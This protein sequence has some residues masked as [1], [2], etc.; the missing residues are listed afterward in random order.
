MDSISPL[1]DDLLARFA[2]ITGPANALTSPDLLAR[3]L[4]EPRDLYAG[5]TRL[6][7]RPASVEEVSAILTLANE[8]R[9][10]VVPQGGNTGL[11]GG[12]SPRSE[13]EIVLSLERMNRIREIDPVGRVLV[14]EA[15][16]VLAQAQSAAEEA[17]LLFP[18]SLG[19][20]GSC[21]IGG[22]LSSNAGGTGVLAYGNAR[23]LC[24]GLEAVLPSGEILNGLRKLK[25][26][27]RGYDWKDLLIGAEGTLGIITAAV[28]RLFPRPAGREVAYVGVKTPQDALTLLGIA[29]RRVGGQL[30]GFE[31]I[32]RQGMAFT[33]A[34]TKGARDPLE[35]AHPWYVLVEISS[36]RSGEDARQA[37]EEVLEAAFEASAVEDAAIAP[38]LVEA[39]RFW[40][41]REELSWAQKPE[42]GS[43]KHDVSV[44]V[45]RV[46]DFLAEADAAV[47]AAMPG[48]RIVAFGH[49]GD[50]NIHYNIS[51]PLGADK[52]AFL[53]RWHEIADIVHGIVAGYDGSF[54]AE[55]GIGQLKRDDLAGAKAGP[56]IELMRRLKGVF[57]PYRILNPGKV[58]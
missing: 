25:K 38:S 43:I 22:N 41:M 33:L 55:H 14:V 45:A 26:D 35:A 29:E 28:L 12:Q 20:Q 37:M 16:V 9:T 54:S 30:T 10:P 3:Y 53:A 34:H 32:G 44:P 47:L 23:D 40:T 42:G 56:E 46:P 18:L 36:S 24:L 39:E 58:V 27:N 6:V 19:S 51:Q 11:V 8:T 49:L 5:R 13:G 17:G 2:A 21:Q 52:A 1:S 48:A 57:D 31:L 50:G 7:L 4:V 15:G